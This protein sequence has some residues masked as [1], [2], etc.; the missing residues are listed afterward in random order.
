MPS[1]DRP[2]LVG[3]GEDELLTLGSC[4]YF[5]KRYAMAPALVFRNR[6]FLSKLV[7]RRGRC[8]VDRLDLR[9]VY[10]R[11]TV[12]KEGHH[13]HSGCCRRPHHRCS[14]VQGMLVPATLPPY[15]GKCSARGG[16]AGWDP[17]RIV[18]IEFTTVERTKASWASEEYRVSK[19]MRLASAET[20][21][22][23]VESVSG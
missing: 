3:G 2:E 11:L 20:R 4:Y 18:V 22:I 12:E 14:Q 23:V 7:A 13:G 19:A 16:R 21:M 6:K 15:G 1:S 8:S 9:S 17:K 5:Y 10:K